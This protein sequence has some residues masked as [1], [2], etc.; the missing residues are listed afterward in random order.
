MQSIN[1]KGLRVKCV[2]IGH[3]GAIGYYSHIYLGNL[4]FKGVWILCVLEML[5]IG[6]AT[7]I[8]GNSWLNLIP[9]LLLFIELGKIL[10]GI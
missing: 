2:N 3:L 6:N 10:L 8:Q 4:N 1:H 7:M 9:L 5:F